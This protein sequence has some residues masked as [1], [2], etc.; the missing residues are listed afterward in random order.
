MGEGEQGE[1]S[2]QNTP[3]V[4]SVIVNGVGRVGNRTGSLC[5]F[6]LP[7]HANKTTQEVQH[8]HSDPARCWGE[9]TGAAQEVG[10][11]DGLQQAGDHQ[12]QA[13]REEDIWQQ[14]TGQTGQ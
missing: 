5:V 10:D 2:P 7:R 11:E 14:E 9:F 6:L 1:V 13:E 4:Q 8:N 3:A 12:G